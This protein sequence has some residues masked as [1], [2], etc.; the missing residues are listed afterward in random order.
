LSQRFACC[1]ANAHA[2]SDLAAFH[3]TS[4]QDE[5][6]VMNQERNSS[7]DAERYWRDGFLFPIRIASESEASGF[8]S[9]F[10]QFEER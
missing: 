4:G 10:E 5:E 6:S 1:A 7:C 3:V 8:R 2:G 9:E